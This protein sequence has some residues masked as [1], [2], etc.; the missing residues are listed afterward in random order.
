MAM[1]S[2]TNDGPDSPN[3]LD[4]TLSELRAASRGDVYS[5]TIPDNVALKAFAER[6]YD[7]ELT[8]ADIGRVAFFPTGDEA[9]SASGGDPSVFVDGEFRRR[10]IASAMYLLVGHELGYQLVQLD[11]LSDD[12]EAFWK[13]L[14]DRWPKRENAIRLE[15]Q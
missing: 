15:I 8:G 3:S 7:A 10:G 13:A 2:G 11:S 6:G 5:G 1:T 9:Y 14:G 4:K 12:G